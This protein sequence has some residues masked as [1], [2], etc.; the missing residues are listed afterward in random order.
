MTWWGAE[1]SS[2]HYAVQTQR[3]HFFSYSSSCIVTEHILQRVSLLSLSLMLRYRQTADMVDLF[4]QNTHEGNETLN[5]SRK[6]TQ[7]WSVRSRWW[8]ENK[9]FN[10]NIHRCCVFVLLFT[11]LHIHILHSFCRANVALCL[12]SA[13]CFTK[14]LSNLFS[15]S[16]ETCRLFLY[17]R[18]CG[19][20]QFWTYNRVRC[21]R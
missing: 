2:V 8:E 7:H 12:S 3:R 18:F 13:S 6:N 20:H 17:H 10:S 9:H 4:T 19:R 15:A 1:S 16:R 21:W 5:C 11:W 14:Y